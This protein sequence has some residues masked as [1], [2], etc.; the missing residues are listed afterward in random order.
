M[1]FLSGLSVPTGIFISILLS[2]SAYGQDMQATLQSLSNE[3]L[4]NHSKKGLQILGVVKLGNVSTTE[5]TVSE[6]S[7]LAWDE[8]EKLLYAIS[9]KGFLV[10]LKPFFDASGRLAD[11][12]LLEVFVLKDRSDQPLSGNFIDSE[13]LQAIHQDNGVKGDTVLLVPF[14]RIPRVL[15]YLPDGTYSGSE[16]IPG[17]LRTISHYKNPNA[18]LESIV[19]H[20][21]YGIITAP[22]KLSGNYPENE[23]QL[24]S[25]AGQ[26][27]SFTNSGGK[28]GSIT[29]MTVTSEG[30]LLA[31][32]RIFHNIFMGVRFSL[33]HIKLD[34]HGTSHKI[35]M[36][37][38]PADGYFNDNFEG[39][40][41]HK[42]NHFF[43]IS[44]DNNS[45]LQRTLLVYFNL[46]ELDE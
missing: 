46:P 19:L 6:F 4:E 28:Y 20:K 16:T 43:M 12:L 22:E 23:F 5:Y 41:H 44:D 7:G 17:F 35:L 11:V 25:L 2:A 33:H 36:D 45:A 32:E 37:I 29:G 34:K 13:G 39:I 8:D 9:D 14:E 1:T 42:D 10:H 3:V 18:S 21:H 31:L 40:A 27:W 26:K 24:F 15:R 38:G 30:N